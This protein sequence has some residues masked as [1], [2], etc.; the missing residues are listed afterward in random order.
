MGAHPLGS[1][2]DETIN[3]FALAIKSGIPA[4][5]LR[6]TVFGYPTLASDVPYML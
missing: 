2:A 1:H 6:E 5:D 4:S 3:L